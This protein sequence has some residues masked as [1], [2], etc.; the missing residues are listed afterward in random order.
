LPTRKA[1]RHRVLGG[2][3]AVLLAGGGGVWAAYAHDMEAANL[4]LQGRSSVVESPY[5]LIEYATVGEGRPVLAVHGSGGGFD[6]ALEMMGPLAD[7]G[8][9]LIA[10]SRF[11][12][13]RSGRPENA[14]P[15]MQADAFAWLLS[16]MGEE[17]VIVAGG[18]AGALPALQFAIRHPEKTEALVL[19]VPTAYSPDR[20]PGESA[21]GGP[22]G[23]SVALSLLKSDFLFWVAMKLA[24]DRMTRALLATEPAVVQAAGEKERARVRAIL[25]HILP[26]SRRAKGLVDDTRWAGT[27]PE[28][29]LDRITAPVLAVSFRDDLYGTYASAEYTAARV[30]DGSFIGFPTGGHV[31]AG[32]GE[33]VWRVVSDFLTGIPGQG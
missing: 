2:L 23:Q 10:P 24:P 18:S 4:R 22:L 7:R 3:T 28:Y 30:K 29:P 33:E 6:Q 15:A 32:R 13:L 8:Y 19:L 5:G 12:Y 1:R 27:P 16:Q 20:K 25:A 14:S 17:K 9:R 11:G 31:F 26:V 21:M